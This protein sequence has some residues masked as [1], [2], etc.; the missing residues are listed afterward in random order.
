[1]RASELVAGRL[2][3]PEGKSPVVLTFDDATNNQVAFFPDGRLDP[4]TAVGIL[5]DFAAEHHGFPATGT[6]YV[7]RN[8][9]DG[10]GRTAEQTFGWLVGHGFELGN[11]TKDHL[12]LSQLDAT[13]VQRQLVLG[14]RLLTDR[15]PGYRAETM[16]LPL[17]TLPHPA[18]LAVHGTWKGE[19]Y[20]FAGV[21]LAGG[22]PAPSPFS[23][24]WNPGEIPRILTN[25]HW[26]GARDFT[27][28]MWLDLL[29]RNPG[30]RYVS[31]G[32]PATISFP[33]A[34]EG[35]LAARYR[36]RARPY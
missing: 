5:A 21:F 10:N 33:H 28:G 20:R 16:A 23:A 24:K 2:D 12:A 35:D 22:E 7:P 18:A 26:R 6:F 11:H 4:R 25:P 29:E 31:D 34:R 36:A 14:N 8:A 1:V 30:L 9:F 19:S 15:L 17:G 13:A 32:D 27:W 3:V